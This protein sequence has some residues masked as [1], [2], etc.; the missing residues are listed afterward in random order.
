MKTITIVRINQTPAGIFGNLSIDGNPICWTLEPQWRMNLKNVSCI[1]P[2]VYFYKQYHSPRFQ[3]ICI[4]LHNI[5]GRDYISMHP[6][7]LLQDTNGCILPGL[8]IGITSG[9]TSVKS[10]NLA[11][12]K[13]ITMT[14]DVGRI[15]IIERF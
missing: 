7:N 3:R 12:D 2:G 8:S 4:Q 6:G 13:I 15:K 11:M 9:H 14:G 5:F 1:L 10:S